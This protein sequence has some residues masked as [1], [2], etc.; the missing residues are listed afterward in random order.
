MLVLENPHGGHE[1]LV[2][3]GPKSKSDEKWVYI[4]LFGHRSMWQTVPNSPTVAP[5][6]SKFESVQLLLVGD[7]ITV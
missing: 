7:T 2:N 4:E 1:V 3:E 5:Q 6:T